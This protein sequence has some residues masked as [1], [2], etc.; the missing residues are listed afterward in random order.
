M[1]VACIQMDNLSL[2]PDQ[3]Y[4]TV[5]ERIEEVAASLRPD[6]IT[7]PET[8]NTGYIPREMKG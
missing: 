4:R 5:S 7:L 6:V 3:N 2:D 8:W 1:K